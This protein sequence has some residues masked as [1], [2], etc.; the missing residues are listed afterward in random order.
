V[1]LV[2]NNYQL[3]RMVVSWPNLPRRHQPQGEGHG[4]SDDDT[5]RWLWDNVSYDIKQWGLMSGIPE[6][7]TSEFREV[8]VGNRLI[9]PDGTV[10]KFI[11]RYLREQVLGLFDKKD[12]KGKR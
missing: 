12:T 1:L 3:M 4:P 2:T 6:N 9:Y 7:F 8:L 5:W 10:N 11:E